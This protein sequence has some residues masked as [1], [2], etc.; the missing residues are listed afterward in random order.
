MYKDTHLSTHKM[1]DAP[2][3]EY[4]GVN[5]KR[6]E[7]GPTLAVLEVC[8]DGECVMGSSRTIVNR[9]LETVVQ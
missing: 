9:G 6:W 3:Q 5:I 4:M 2:S 7:A 8:G 1:I